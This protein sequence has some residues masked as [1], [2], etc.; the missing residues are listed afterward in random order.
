MSVKPGFATESMGAEE[1]VRTRLPMLKK[2]ME[3]RG[4]IINDLTQ[5]PSFRDRTANAVMLN[6]FR[7]D[8]VESLQFKHRWV[9]GLLMVQAVLLMGV[10]V[11]ARDRH[12]LTTR[13]KAKTKAPVVSPSVAGTSTD[14]GAGG[15]AAIAEGKVTDAGQ[16]ALAEPEDCRP[17]TP[18]MPWVIEALPYEDGNNT[19]R[20]ETRSIDRYACAPKRNQAGPEVWYQITLESPGRLVANLQENRRSGVDVDLH[21]LTGLTSETCIR[22]NDRRIRARLEPGTYYLVVDTNVRG[23][24]RAGP[25]TLSVRVRP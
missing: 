3:Q 13:P 4:K 19:R 11:V 6:R 23:S 10:M 24:E 12:R 5:E 2:R 22:R 9:Q 25:Y 20:S 7:A 15:V 8:R 14:G 1:T 18:C 16:P 21:L 17:G